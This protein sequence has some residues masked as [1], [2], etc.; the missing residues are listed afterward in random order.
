FVDLGRMATET[1]RL[2]LGRGKGEVLFERRPERR[3]MNRPRQRGGLPF[4]KGALVAALALVGAGKGLVQGRLRSILRQTPRRQRSK[5]QAHRH[6]H[7]ATP[8]PETPDQWLHALALL[9]FAGSHGPDRAGRWSQG[10]DA[11]RE[12]ARLR[13]VVDQLGGRGL[14]RF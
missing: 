6:D 12:D 14:L 11:E 4:L 1:D 8:E 3:R 10:L 5:R 2:V 9:L 13:I 7:P